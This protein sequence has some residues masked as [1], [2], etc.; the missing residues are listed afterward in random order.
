MIIGQIDIFIEN[1]RQ[2]NNFT[3]KDIFNSSI[4]LYCI[5]NYNFLKLS[6]YIKNLS[7]EFFENNNFNDIIAQNDFINAITTHINTE[8]PGILFNIKKDK[9]I[10]NYDK[11]PENN[12]L[13]SAISCIYKVVDDKINTYIIEKYKL[14]YNNAQMLEV[15][16]VYNDRFYDG[17]PDLLRIKKW[18]TTK[19][20]TYHEEKQEDRIESIIN[21][22]DK[23]DLDELFYI[24]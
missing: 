11:F 23:I 13:Y 22:I 5:D 21:S 18:E 20:Y 3:D 7:I 8:F 1:K 24:T 14:N 19:K 2:E 6:R 17:I 15:S 16:S 10:F 9:I 12:I 4:I